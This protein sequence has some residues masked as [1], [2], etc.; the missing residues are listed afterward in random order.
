M[1]NDWLAQF[2]ASVDGYN[3]SPRTQ[4]DESKITAILQQLAQQI[5]LAPQEGSLTVSGLDVIAVPGRAGR[6]VDVDA[7]RLALLNAAR[8]GQ[9]GVVTL[10]VQEPLPAVRSV[11]KAAARATALLAQPLTLTAQG[12]EGSQQFAVDRATLR[13]WLQFAATPSADGTMDLQARLD[14]GQVTAYL[15][16][17][18]AQLDRPMHDAVLDFDPATKQLSV[19]KPSQ[20][21]QH[22]DVKAGVE[23][24]QAAVNGPAF[25]DGSAARTIAI[26]VA[27]VQ[28]KVDSA[29]T[30][31]LGIVDVVSTGTTSFAGSSADRVHNIAAA[32]NKF[33]NVVV[34][35]G[36]D[37]SFNRYVGAITSANGFTD[38]L[39]ISGD[40]TAVGVGGGV[41]QVSTTVYR[42]ALTGGFPITQR[43]AHGY[44][45]GWYGKPGLDATIY[46]PD[47]DFRFNN[48]TGHYL[49]IRSK[50][51]TAKGQITFTI[52]GT[53]INRTV[54]IG[55]PQISNVRDP[56]KPVYR[57]DKTLAPGVI[58]QVDWAVKG[59]DTVVVRRVK[60]ADGKVSEERIQ[61]HYQPWR[62][63]Y[64]YGPGTQLPAG[65]Q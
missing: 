54:E 39:V 30:A 14:A 64:L 32:A 52:Y 53:K 28:P 57:E 41:C 2:R 56:E 48:D 6:R 15:Q 10:V 65:A 3:V 61:S 13:Q 47:V 16:E 25:L 51:D 19:V 1:Q 23:A 27:I 22:V 49:F 60:G 17:I 35:P 36:E 20:V 58:K 24:I 55:D 12:H 63:V 59:M 31:E 45:V 34:P 9:G 11:D 7:T 33:Q 38:G 29:K 21:G 18:A 40:R 44:V 8:D 37:F 5:D 26:P 46:T 50:V 42:A 4:L 43:Y 62:A